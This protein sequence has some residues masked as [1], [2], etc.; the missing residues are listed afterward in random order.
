MG[1]K[2]GSTLIATA[3]I[4]IG[5]AG[6][7]ALTRFVETKRPPAP[8][9]Y[10][11][12]DLALQ[13]ARLKGFVFGAEGLVADWYWMNSLQ[14][15]GRKISSV[16]LNNLNL[17]DMTNLNPR[18]LYPYLNT[19]TELD[20]HFMA[21]YSYGAT[22]LPAID[23]AQAIELTEKGIRNNPDHWR[24]YQYLGYIHWRLK[25]YEK[26]AETYTR[27]SQVKDA[28]DFF[29][30]MAAKMKTEGGSRDVAR[31]IYQQIVDESQDAASRKSAALRLLQLDSLD[32]RDVINPAL[33]A[34]KER[35]GRCATKWQEILPLLA[36]AKLPRGRELR[37]DNANNLVDPTGIP[38][39][40][41]GS[42]C[43]AH[44]EWPTSKIPPI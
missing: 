31:E 8:A 4:V 9:G 40:L 29:A 23:P 32:D 43:E 1:S 18:L 22:I 14:Y 35:N 24:L 15:I 13:G 17:D 6:V 12:A 26:A 36:N 28:P 39:R 3:V 21:P 19:A 42:L 30:M 41:V 44:I 10:E 16:G 20:P 38:Y 27:G 34:F 2:S 25:D 7:F 11:D 37:I 33:R 5:F